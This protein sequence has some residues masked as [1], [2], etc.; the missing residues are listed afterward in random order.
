[1]VILAYIYFCNSHC[2][3]CPYTAHPHVRGKFQEMITDEVFEKI[4]DEV[5]KHKSVLRITGGGEPFLHP[6]IVEHMKYATRKGCRVSII[7]NGSMDVTG[8]VNVVDMIEF[9][10]DAGNRKDYAKARPGLNWDV[11]NSN[12][13]KAFKKRKKTRLITSVINQKGIDIEQAKKHWE[14]ADVVQIRKFLSF[15]AN[16]DNSADKTPYLEEGTPCPWPFDRL[17]MNTEGDF[18]ICNIDHGFEYKFSNINEM[19]IKEAWQSKAM[20]ILRE[21]HLSGKTGELVLCRNCEDR[22]YRSWNQSYF[23]LRENAGSNHSA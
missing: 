15:N 11:L 14:F 18:T 4:A 1:M 12:V 7:T 6:K 21:K 20:K 23:K 17:L 10:V 19:S 5:G 8:L 16:E 22:K 2:P 13:L 9:S 3:Y